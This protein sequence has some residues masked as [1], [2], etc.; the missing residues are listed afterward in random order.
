M[1]CRYK[2]S[3]PNYWKA[4]DMQCCKQDCAAWHKE[5]EK[6]ADLYKITCLDD[7][8]DYVVNIWKALEILKCKS[9]K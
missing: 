3:N 7:I 4:D 6:C 9:G 2:F 8:A 5:S 1:L